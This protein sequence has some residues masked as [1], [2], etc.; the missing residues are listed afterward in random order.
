MWR[1][2]RPRP[3]RERRSLW[4]SFRVEGCQ[5]LWLD[6]VESID[7]QMPSDVGT[8]CIGG[9]EALIRAQAAREPAPV[10]QWAPPYC[11]DIGIR[12]RADGVWLYRDSPIG[13]A[14]PL[15]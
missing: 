12:I 4:R 8:N 15:Q 14:E 5:T 7:T 9:L 10:E 3:I 6:T 11:G 13:R 1:A 2:R